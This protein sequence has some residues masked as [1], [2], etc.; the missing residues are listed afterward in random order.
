MKKIILLL[1]TQAVALHV[2]MGCKFDI[3][4]LRFLYTVWSLQVT[5]KLKG[6]S[7]MSL[8][9]TVEN[10]DTSLTTAYLALSPGF[11]KRPWYCF[12]L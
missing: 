2:C 12:L 9:L 10:S 1:V 6:S 11:S 7:C 5:C 3:V 4:H 8:F